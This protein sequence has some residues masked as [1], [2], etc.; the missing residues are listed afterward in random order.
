M[1]GEEF[2]TLKNAIIAH[3]SRYN[4]PKVKQLQGIP[5]GVVSRV[6]KWLAGAQLNVLHIECLYLCLNVHFSLFKGLPVVFKCWQR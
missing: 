1:E 4:A 3:G 5:S 2:P 6:G